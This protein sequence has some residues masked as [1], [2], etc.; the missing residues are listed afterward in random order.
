MIT[1][2]DIFLFCPVYSIR[3]KERTFFVLLEEEIMIFGNKKPLKY[4]DIKYVELSSRRNNTV[5]YIELELI[6]REY[7]ETRFK[8]KLDRI[9]E[10]IEILNDKGIATAKVLSQLESKNILNIS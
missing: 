3:S 1:P 4:K 7:N 10:V 8:V 2:F 5:E 9:Q 6:D